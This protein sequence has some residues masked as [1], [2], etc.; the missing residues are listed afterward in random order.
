MDLRNGF[1]SDG[2]ELCNYIK[3]MEMS[4]SKLQLF[5]LCSKWAAY[6][7]PRSGMFSDDILCIIEIFASGAIISFYLHLSVKIMHLPHSLIKA[8]T[9]HMRLLWIFEF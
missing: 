5:C 8:I 3:L 7:Q 6:H 9:V 1:S 2:S 4:T